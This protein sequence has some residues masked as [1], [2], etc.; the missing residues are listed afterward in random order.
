MSALRERLLT[1]NFLKGEKSPQKHLH[2]FATK[3]TENVFALGGE[4]QSDRQFLDPLPGPTHKKKKCPTVENVDESKFWSDG[5]SLLFCP[6]VFSWWAA[7]PTT[8]KP[9]SMG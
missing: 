3:N 9:F 7:D 6:A 8:F 1:C 4:K 5:R 2:N